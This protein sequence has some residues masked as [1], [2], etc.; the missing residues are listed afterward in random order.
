MQN[1]RF[2]LTTCL[3]APFGFIPLRW[4][5]AI[6]GKLG[7]FLMKYNYKRA[8]IARCNLKACFPDKTDT[9]REELLRLNAI[10]TGK[11]FMESAHVWFRHPKHL[12][13]KV[14]VKN[15]EVL[16]R[17]HQQKRG[18][19]IVLPHMGNWELLNFYIPQHYAFAAMYKPIKSAWFEQLT[20]RSRSR[21]GT[22]MFP[23]NSKGVRQALKS[24][25][26][27]NVLAILSDHLP[28]REA[29]V[30][31]PFF[32]NPAL[33]GKLT[34]SLVNSNQSEALLASVLRKPKGQGFEI[35][36]Q[37]IEGIHTKD[38]IEAATA[39]NQAIEK[40]ILLCPEQYQWVYRR[41][42]NPPEGVKNIYSK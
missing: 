10:E 6:G 38:N 5:Q 25:R 19:V 7:L 12:I 32:G 20:F 2:I 4:S 35:I 21:L 14:S 3:L 8:H 40:S 42:G 18:V 13:Q 15:P 41:F 37:K 17:A 34:Q 9:E 36:F 16:E 24:M 27:N 29:G 33:T 39:L 28:S 23:T 31:A 30:Y 1:I 22:Q 26:N 11:W